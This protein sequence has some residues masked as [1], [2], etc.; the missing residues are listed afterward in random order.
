MENRHLQILAQAGRRAILGLD[1]R[2]RPEKDREN[3]ELCSQ[4]DERVASSLLPG[5]RIPTEVCNLQGLAEFDAFRNLWN[6]WKK[7][8]KS[9]KKRLEMSLQGGKWETRYW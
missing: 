1:F 7:Y 3:K 8:M 9:K 5:E 6:V 4:L 2:R